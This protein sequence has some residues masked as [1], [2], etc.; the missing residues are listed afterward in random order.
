MKTIRIKPKI[1]DL[2]PNLP[3]EKLQF[4]KT[5]NNKLFI[6]IDNGVTGTIGCIFNN[7]SWFFETYVKKEQN[8]TKA[9]GNIS[10]VIFKELY[11]KLWNIILECSN[12]SVMCLIERPMINPTRFKASISAVRA[13]ETT[14]NVI[15]ELELPYQYEDSKAWQKELLPKGIKGNVALKAASKTI[16]CRLFPQHFELITKH[17]D[18]DGIFLAEF[19]R[20]KF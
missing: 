8:Y 13:L 11:L 1:T 18:A 7:K 5:N 15:E 2:P 9:K 14:L 12:P 4:A 6:G 3:K 10:R 20:R 16:G 19:C 17:K